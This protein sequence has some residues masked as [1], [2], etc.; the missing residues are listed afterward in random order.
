MAIFCLLKYME[1]QKAVA[2]IRKFYY[3]RKRLPSYREVAKLLNFKSVNAAWCVVKKMIE[4]GYLDKDSRGKLIPQ[5]LGQ[6]LKV[7]G[8]VEAGFP[9]L[10]N[11]EEIDTI[12]LD[13]YLLTCPEKNYML[14]VIG[15][16]M[17]EAGI[18]PDDLVIAEKDKEPRNGDVVIAEVDGLWT[19]KYFQ[20]RNKDIVLIPANKDYP[21]I[22]PKEELKIGGVVVSVIRKYY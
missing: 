21:S 6:E 19:M 4:Q 3:E 10:A 14:K 5:K 13:Q 20:K 11:Q 7:L 22:Y 15:L 8:T 12:S 9:T 2:K 17:I 18:A 1:I 16:S